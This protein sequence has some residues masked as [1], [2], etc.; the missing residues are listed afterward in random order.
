MGATMLLGLASCSDDH[1]DIKNGAASANNTIWQNL[2]ANSDKFSD[3]C[4]ILQKVRVYKSLEDKKRTLTYAELLNQP[5]TLTFWAPVNGSF[6]PQPYLSRIDQINSYREQG[7]TDKADTLE[8]NLG[9]Q[10]AQNHL[11]RFNFESSKENQDV[12]L[13]NSKLATYNAGEGLFNGVEQQGEEIPSSNGVLHALNGVSPFAFNIYDY[14]GEHQDEFPTIY[15]ALTDPTTNKRIFS[16]SSSTPGGMNNEGQMVYIDSVYTYTNELLDQSGAQIKNEDSLYVAIIPKESAYQQAKEK[17]EKLFNYASRYKYNYIGGGTISAA[18][19][20]PYDITKTDSLRDYNTK[21]MLMTSMY[22]TPS[23]F[24]GRFP[25][26]TSRDKKAEIADY[27]MHADSLISTNGLIFYNS[28]KGGLNPMFGDGNWE[29]ASNGVIFPISTYDSD[30]AYSIM[31]SQTLD[32]LNSS[33]VGDVVIGGA[34]GSKG[35]Y[36]YLTEGTNWNKDI[37]IDMLETKGYRYFQVDARV[38]QALEVYIPLRNLY[39]GKYR[40]RVQMLP[41][42]VDNNHKYFTENEETNEQEEIVEQETKFVA[43]LYDDEG[44]RIG[45]PSEDITVDDHEVK[46]YTLFESIEIP[47]CYYNLPSGVSNCFPLLKLEIPGTRKY[48]PYYRTQFSGLSITKIFID[49]VRE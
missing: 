39:S 24:G 25:I 3:V 17:V 37:D 38:T 47:K 11:A 21:K 23:I 35:S 43:T 30:P 20:T 34:S 13:Y 36:Y 4:S 14:I 42:R 28:N 46:T 31:Q 29:E 32:M 2:Q 15:N 7:L 8:Y 26:S 16:E 33:N 27:A 48:R 10:F 6:D 5:Q 49:P 19:T 40:I 45:S 12:R 44:K 1:F 22:F 41:N 9:M 18:F